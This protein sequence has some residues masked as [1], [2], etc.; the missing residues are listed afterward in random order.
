LYVNGVQ[1][2]NFDTF[3]P[4]NKDVDTTVNGATQAAIGLSG[5]NGSPNLN[6]TL[7]GYYFID[8][9]AALPTSFG[10]LTGADWIP[11]DYTGSFGSGGFELLFDTNYGDIPSPTSTGKDTSG[12]D[13]DFAVFKL[14]TG[15]VTGDN[16]F[17]WFANPIPSPISYLGVGQ[18][19]SGGILAAGGDGVGGGGGGG[20][21]QGTLNATL[22]T[23]YG[24]SFTTGPSTLGTSVTFLGST[25]GAGSPGPVTVNFGS[26]GGP[27]GTPQSNSGGLGQPGGGGGGGAGGAGSPQNNNNGGGGGPGISSSIRGTSEGFGSGGGGTPVG[28][29]PSG[30]GAGGPW[31]G[32]GL[33][34]GFPSS[35]PDTVSIGA[36]VTYTALNQGGV[37]SY[38][39]TALSSAA[40]SA[41]QGGWVVDSPTPGGQ[42]DTGA[43]GVVVGN[44]A[45]LNSS[46]NGGA[47]IG[48]GGLTYNTGASTNLK[49][50]S[51]LAMSG[52][53]YYWEVQVPSGSTI[54]GYVGV[55]KSSSSLTTFPGGDNSSYGFN[56]SSGQ[57]ITNNVATSYGNAVSTGQT[58]GIAFNATNGTLYFA[59]NNVWQNGGNPANTVNPAFNN[60]TSGPYFAAFGGSTS[61]TMYVNFG[62]KPY[63]YNAPTG[64]GSLL[65]D[66]VFTTLTFDDST[67]LSDFQ[68]GDQV[69]ELS[70][71]ATGTVAGVNVGT[72]QMT[73]SNE[74]G[75]WTIGSLVK[76]LSRTVPAGYPTTD[77][78]NP[79]LYPLISSVSNSVINLTSYPVGT[80]PLEPSITYYARV[81]YKSSATVTESAWSPFS[82]FTTGNLT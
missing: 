74:A 12:N 41:L 16:G 75:V 20:V 77:P 50:L 3:I 72:N 52:G 15:D 14:Y 29:G 25:A 46:A 18:G 2:T 31:G 63:V 49:V 30:G 38:T 54:G 6:A 51:T 82:K 9:T 1:V 79:V 17:G 26:P 44:Y 35:Q 39:I 68:V 13:N 67:Y 36:G 62:Q 61:G 80:P 70:G 4:Y 40:T 33:I 27:S 43:G 24:V 71:D 10:Q 56:T 11:V 66:Q 5:V 55:A 78:P 60:L 45:I 28:G 8:G 58:L 47:T 21:I 59:I 76:D 57:V 7:T 65:E 53:K 32:A 19:G 48:S 73:V 37:K 81:K 64:Y 22:G 34:I 42:S 23:A 69:Q